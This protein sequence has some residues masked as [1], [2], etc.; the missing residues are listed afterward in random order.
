MRYVRAFRVSRSGQGAKPSVTGR[1]QAVMEVPDINAV[2]NALEGAEIVQ[3]IHDTPYGAK[4]IIAKEPG[5]HF[6]IFSQLS[7]QP[8]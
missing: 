3:G 4:E 2:V 6:V 5:G 7:K 8:Q 1:G